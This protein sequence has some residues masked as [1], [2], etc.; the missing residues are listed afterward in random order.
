M[1]L[2][3]QNF[4]AAAAHVLQSITCV[5]PHSRCGSGTTACSSTQPHPPQSPTSCPPCPA[6]PCASA[7]AMVESGS[8]IQAAISAGAAGGGVGARKFGSVRIGEG[9]CG[10]DGGRGMGRAKAQ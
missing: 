9:R 1:M 7:P 4:A 3:L 10:R 5:L 6:A 8:V 2:L